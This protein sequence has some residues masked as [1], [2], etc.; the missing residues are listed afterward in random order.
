MIKLRA[1]T[2][3]SKEQFLDCIFSSKELIEE[4][5]EQELF[6]ALKEYFPIKH[7]VSE[8]FKRDESGTVVSIEYVFRAEIEL[9]QEE[10]KKYR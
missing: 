10:F 6:R 4:K 1:E 3:L 8:R 2:V 7:T 5:H 9:T